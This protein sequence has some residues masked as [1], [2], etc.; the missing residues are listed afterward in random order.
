MTH[1]DI[2]AMKPGRELDALV[3]EKVMGLQDFKKGTSGY[4]E[5]EYVYRSDLG[6]IQPIP[7]YSTNI[8]AAW[9][10]VKKMALLKD[11]MNF[12]LR[13]CCDDLPQYNCS[14]TDPPG[15]A[16]VSADNAPEAICKAALLV[17][18]SNA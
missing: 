7:H 1:E 5:W 8:S 11:V 12:R 10:V 18:M 13:L 17:V 6:D 3:A 14:F 4:K 2:L 16:F 9:E 15:I